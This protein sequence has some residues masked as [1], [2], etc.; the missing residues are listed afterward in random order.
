MEHKKW[1]A[2]KIGEIKLAKEGN[3]PIVS[4]MLGDARLANFC[5]CFIREAI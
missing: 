3:L 5:M 2:L 4:I 1:P